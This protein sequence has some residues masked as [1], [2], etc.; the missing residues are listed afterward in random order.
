MWQEAPSGFILL[1]YIVHYACE[2]GD[3]KQR[4]ERTALPDSALLF[5]RGRGRFVVADYVLR[6]GVKRHDSLDHWFGNAEAYQRA[7]YSLVGDGVEG[8]CPVEAN[9][10][11][12]LVMSLKFLQNAADDVY[13]LGGG[14]MWSESVLC[15]SQ[16]GFERHT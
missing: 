8:L 7:L 5:V 6:V 13:R 10:L 14:P 15:F 1:I 9:N 4:G 16:S 2:D 12:S 11:E 3:E